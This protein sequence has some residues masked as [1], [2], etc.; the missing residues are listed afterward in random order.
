[1]PTRRL[2]HKKPVTPKF[3][4]DSQGK[5]HAM[6]KTQRKILRRL[7]QGMEIRETADQ[8][9]VTVQHVNQFFNKDCVQTYLRQFLDAGGIT[10]SKLIR[11]LNEGLDSQVQKEYCEKGELI[12]GVPRPDHKERREHLQIALRLKGYD[13]PPEPEKLA[14]MNVFSLYQIVVQARRERGL[15]LPKGVGDDVPETGE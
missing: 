5:L 2:R 6:T 1:M 4:Q 15:P 12:Q 3:L 14:G 11:R 13:R 7:R 10:D 8:T 9:R